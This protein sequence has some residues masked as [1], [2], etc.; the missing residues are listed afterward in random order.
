MATT[1]QLSLS[2]DLEHVKR[3]AQTLA[4]GGAYTVADALIDFLDAQNMAGSG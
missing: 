2:S 4:N 1:Q 3:T